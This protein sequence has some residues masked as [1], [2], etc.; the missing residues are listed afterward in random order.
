MDVIGI[1]ISI[2]VSV[3]VEKRSRVHVSGESFC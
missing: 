1:A 3:L 2:P